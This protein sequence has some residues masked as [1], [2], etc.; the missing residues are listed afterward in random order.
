MHN[1]CQLYTE[2]DSAQDYS[3]RFYLESHLEHAQEEP[4]TEPRMGRE[5]LCAELT[6]KTMHGAILP[7]DG[8]PLSC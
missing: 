2:A 7:D 1:S 6:Q 8:L 5:T 3:L 4:T